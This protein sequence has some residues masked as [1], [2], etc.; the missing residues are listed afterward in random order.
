MHVQLSTD[1]ILLSAL[2]GFFQNWLETSHN[3]TAGV[4]VKSDKGFVT[5]GKTK[6]I[7]IYRDEKGKLQVS[8]ASV[9]F[10]TESVTVDT[11][12]ID[13]LKYKRTHCHKHECS[14]R[15][16]FA[17]QTLDQREANRSAR[18]GRGRQ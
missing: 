13:H 14:S 16:H 15:N 17:K 5:F 11:T 8:A 10:A 7:K 12:F 2:S 4:Q 3:H 18:R 9:N 6:D 1:K